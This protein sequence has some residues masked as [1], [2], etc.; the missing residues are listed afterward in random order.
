MLSV[1]TRRTSSFLIFLIN[2]LKYFV[3]LQEPPKKLVTNSNNGI[4]VG[5]DDETMNITCNV[6]RGVPE[7]ETQMFLYFKEKIINK[8]FAEMLIHTF[9]PRKVNNGDTFKCVVENLLLESPLEETIRLKVLCKFFMSFL[10]RKLIFFFGSYTMSSLSFSYIA[11][12]NADE[13][14]RRKA[15]QTHNFFDQVIDC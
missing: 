8:T 14:K 10:I 5:H 6:K 4:V 15:L 9:V 12:T 2:M 7:N 11:L 3:S 13:D 1:S